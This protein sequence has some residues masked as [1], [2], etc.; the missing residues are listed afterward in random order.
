VGRAAFRERRLLF[1]ACTSTGAGRGV[2]RR[3]SKGID[4]HRTI[5]RATALGI[6][7]DV[8]L[9]VRAANGIQVPPIVVARLERIYYAQASRYAA[10]REE[11]QLVLGAFADRGIPVI[12]LKGAYLAA[13]VYANVALRPMR[14]LDVLVRAADLGRAGDELERLG[15]RPNES[16]RSRQWYLDQAFHHLV[17]YASPRGPAIVEVHRELAPVSLPIKLP[18]DGLWR[19]AR[20]VSRPLAQELALAPDDLLLHLAVH[21]AGADGF[22]DGVRV[23][24]DVREIV[25]RLGPEIEW[26]R[27]VET[28]S[29]CGVER[30]AYF[31]LRLARRLL[32]VAVPD[33][34][35]EALERAGRVGHAERWAVDRFGRWAALHPKFWHAP[36]PPSWLAGFP[37]ALVA[38]RSWPA[39]GAAAAGGIA[40][41]IERR[42]ER[43]RDAPPPAPDSRLSDQA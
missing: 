29:A 4:W 15:Y 5:R 3:A 41:W 26:R 13:Q 38:R 11:L 12:L 33:S 35:L 30:H 16:W 40:S 19:R 24:R 9:H 8:L 31:T 36:I 37:A 28:A 10:L 21:L 1:D 32:R 27:L 25:E 6:A 42:I 39:R 14:D 20:P 22:L 7:G 18:A 2:D 34:C 17:P 23:L 43:R